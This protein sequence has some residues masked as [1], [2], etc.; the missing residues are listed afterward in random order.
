MKSIMTIFAF[1]LLTFTAT[2]QTGQ[3]LYAPNPYPKTISVNGSAEMEIVPDEIFVQI[4]LGEYQKKGETVK[5]LEKIKAEFLAAYKSTGMPDS[6]ISIA[7]YSGANNYY[8]QKKKKKPTDMLAEIT[9]QVKFSSSKQMDALVEKL[10][11]EATKSF[12]I[13]ST[14]HSRITE[15]RKQLKIKAVQAARD[16]GIYLSEAIGEKLGDA[17]T[18]NEPTEWQPVYNAYSQ[19]AL[20]SNTAV[21]EDAGS[22]EVDFKKIK[23]RFEVQV[24]FALK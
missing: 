12:L 15:F 11:D 1:A 23:L 6:L 13:V 14:S 19:M 16:K 21:T 18:I 3:P 9:Y 17:I 22:T 24:T 2:A 7:A 8:E 10:D 20:R 5:S 4:R